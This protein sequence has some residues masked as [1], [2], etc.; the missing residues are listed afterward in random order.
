METGHRDNSYLDQNFPFSILGL[1]F[2]LV[3]NDSLYHA[4]YLS[5]HKNVNCLNSNTC[6]IEFEEVD[7]ISKYF[8]AILLQ[9]FNAVNLT[10][11]YR[12]KIV[13]SCHIITLL[14][15]RSL[16]FGLFGK[17]HEFH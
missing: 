1:L 16:M 11:K 4:T 2:L 10:K 13:Q 15:Y 14:K 12:N 6:F 3:Y 8:C 5:K 7:P 17:W 9:F